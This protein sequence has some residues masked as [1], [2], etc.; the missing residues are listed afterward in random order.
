M[1]LRDERG[2]GDCC[3]LAL[4]WVLQREEEAALYSS[5]CPSSSSSACYVLHPRS[6]MERRFGPLWH[7][8]M[9]QGTAAE[10]DTDLRGTTRAIMVQCFVPSGDVGYTR[11]YVHRAACRSLRR[12]AG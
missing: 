11:S 1:F 12:Y 5:Y 7:Q 10:A 9:K 6:E 4:Y 8:K 3:R 2:Q